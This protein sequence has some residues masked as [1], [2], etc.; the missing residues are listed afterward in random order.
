MSVKTHFNV[1][2]LSRHNSVRS[3]IAE[4]V[5][6]RQGRGNFTSFSAGITP[7]ESVDPIVLDI[8]TVAEYPTEGLHAKSWT[9]F[10][11]SKAPPLDFVFTLCDLEAGEEACQW[12][13]RPITGTWRYPDPE[14]IVGEDW[15]RRKELSTILAGL[16]RQLT[17]FMFLPYKSLDSISLEKQLQQAASQ[18]AG[19]P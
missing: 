19:N 2:F 9:E 3:I 16:E 11:G 8:L 14:K 15:Q 6:R 1:L 12:P 4:S 17:A 5:L 13:G 10:A 18:F 7:G